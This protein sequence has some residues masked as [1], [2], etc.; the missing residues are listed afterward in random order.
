MSYTYGLTSQRAKNRPVLT[1]LLRHFFLELWKALENCLSQSPQSH[2]Q[3]N[4]ASTKYVQAWC[5]SRV[6]RSCNV[7]EF[8]LITKNSKTIDSVL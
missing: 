5:L 1:H 2:G 3:A 8:Q 7:T 6:R 4:V